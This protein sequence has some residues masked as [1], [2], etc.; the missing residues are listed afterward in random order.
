MLVP[1]NC[2][3]TI[4]KTFRTSPEEIVFTRVVY[5]P[6]PIIIS[7]WLDSKLSIYILSPFPLPNLASTHSAPSIP[8]SIALI[9]RK[10]TTATPGKEVSA[11]IWL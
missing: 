7:W 6:S 11:T 3:R 4:E 8:V 9:S 1:D 2:T 10:A 5:D